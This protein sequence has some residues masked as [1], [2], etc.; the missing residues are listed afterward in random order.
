MPPMRTKLAAV[1]L[2]SV[3]AL[4]CS[5]SSFGLPSGRNVVR[6]PD[7]ALATQ[8][9]GHAAMLIIALTIV[10]RRRLDAALLLAAAA[11]LPLT[12]I[13]I[14]LGMSV[15][16]QQG[17]LYDPYQHKFKY[18]GLISFINNAVPMLRP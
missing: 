11:I 17:F 14:Q 10:R 7:S 5:E 15:L 1:V 16:T 13:L 8:I 18:F 4:S 6:M 2:L 9:L 12:S 3:L